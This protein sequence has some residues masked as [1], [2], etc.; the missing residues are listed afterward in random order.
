MSEDSQ[1]FDKEKEK[2]DSRETEDKGMGSIAAS[3][4]RNRTVM[5]TPEITDQVRAMLGTDS[6][7]PREGAFGG[8]VP[9][10]KPEFSSPASKASTGGFETPSVGKS[11]EDPLRR[12][13]VP[14]EESGRLGRRENTSK[15]T[16]P[17]QSRAGLFEMDRGSPSDQASIGSQQNPTRNLASG[18]A[19][20][21]PGHEQRAS[22]YQESEVRRAPSPQPEKPRSKIVGFLVS[23]D[24][25]SSGEVVDIR[26][27]RWLLTSKPTSHGEFILIEDESISP[28]HA[29]IRAT[30]DGKIQVLDQLSEFGTGVLRSGASVEEEITGAMGTVNHG[31]TLRFGN[32]R[33]VVCV[34]P[35]IEKKDDEAKE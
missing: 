29:I 12:T 15:M 20:V 5:L 19:P 18:H 24:N 2:R 35:H 28:L 3:R 25:S 13:G 31:D 34:I 9:S 4:A 32:R 17:S 11:I 1:D 10:A 6:E 7:A 26:I 30:T 21:F 16:M 8:Y 22:V 33:F 27:G 23:F 14:G